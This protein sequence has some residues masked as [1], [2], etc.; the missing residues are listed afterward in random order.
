MATL[1]G[2]LSSI[3][4][5]AGASILGNV[6]GTALAAN[7]TL[8]TNIETYGNIA[9]VQQFANVMSTAQVSGNVY[10]SLVNLGSN[11][12]FPALTNSIPTG[13][14]SSLGNTTP[15][16]LTGN[17][18][19]QSNNLMGGGD[20]GIFAQIIGSSLGFVTTSN[21]IIRSAKNAA[22]VI[23]TNQDNVSTGGV[24]NV[25]SAFAAIGQDLANLGRLIDL[26]NLD[27]LGDPSALLKQIDAVSYSLPTLTAALITEG[28]SPED[29][30]NFGDIAFT[31]EMERMAYKAMTKV[32][33]T[34]LA[35]ILS[36]LS[37]KTPNINTVA[38]LLNP[39]KIFPSSFRTLT[40]PTSNGLRGIYVDNSGTVNSK[41]ET[42]L[43]S[44]VLYPLNGNP[45]Q[46]IPK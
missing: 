11:M 9:I 4:L 15:S 45:T 17:V 10:I 21:R 36:V 14:I 13:Y 27:N 39:Y 46:G 43:P 33:G 42:E 28:F 29:A 23:Y 38:D 32:T 1:R 7:S 24:S 34:E 5:V 40:A 22:G 25:S 19:T 8:T 2:S 35:Q 6:G 44:S 20:L 3:N 41:L 37:I 26:T 30:E 16:G 12:S 31:P 18:N